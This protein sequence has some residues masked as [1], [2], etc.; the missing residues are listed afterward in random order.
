MTVLPATFVVLPGRSADLSV[1]IRSEAATKQF[2]GQVT[3]TPATPAD[4]PDLHLPVAFVPKP[5]PVTVTST[6]APASIPVGGTSLCTVTATNSAFEDATVDL[7]TTLDPNLAVAGAAGAMIVDDHRLEVRQAKLPGKV[8]GTPSLESGQLFG[9]VPLDRFDIDPEP[10]GDEE[11]VNF[12]LPDPVSYGGQS[13]SKVGVTSN[14]YLVVGGGDSA[15]VQCCDLTQLPDPARPN[16][17]LAPFWTDLSGDQ[18]PGILAGLL[19]EADGSTWL[20]VEWRLNVYGTTSLRTFQTW[21]RVGA[22]EEI[23]FAYPA[24]DR[25][26]DPGKPL[27]IGAE[28]VNGSGGDQL[29]TGLAP[30]GDLLVRTSAPVPGGSLTYSVTVRGTAAGAGT[31][32]TRMDSP[33]VPGV[34]TVSSTVT[35]KGA[36]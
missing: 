7:T 15:D 2:F 25:P 3:L 20:V 12:D 33:Q 4:G 24:E 27:I 16:N 10:I 34:T 17:V 19:E 35:V 31:V 13:Y 5:G 29:P 36:S 11:I 1:S 32:A 18:A 9:Y 6:C 14:G 22:E 28:N 8:P 23:A 30:A 21:M 26:G